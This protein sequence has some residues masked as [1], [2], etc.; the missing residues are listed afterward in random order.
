METT[1]YSPVFL[2]KRKFLIVAP[3]LM[4]PFITLFF[5][6][7]G[8]GKAAAADTTKKTEPDG[9]NL[10]LPE[11]KTKDEK[12]YNKLSFYE[13]ASKDS[14]KFQEELRNDPYSK[15]SP[16]L[17]TG[18]DTSASELEQVAEQSATRYGQNI[19][20]G[21]KSLNNTQSNPHNYT[22][23][24]EEKVMRKLEQLQNEINAKPVEVTAKTVGYDGPTGSKQM[25]PANP[26]VEKL[27]KMMS[28][29]KK[30]NE[31]DTEMNNINAMLD[32]IMSIQHPERIED[33]LR[34]NSKA[35]RGQVFMVSPGK[36]DQNLDNENANGTSADSRFNNMEDVL[37]ADDQSQH[38]I[39][40][41]IQETR[42]LVSGATVKLRLLNNIYINGVL[43]PRNNFV[44]G[45]VSLKGE[46]LTIGINNINYQNSLFPVS[47][48][49]YD[50]DG[51]EG[52]NI[53]GAITRD[54]AKQSA[55]RAIQG[56]GLT[57]L[58]PSFSAQAAG[59]GIEAAKSLLS[60]K[61]RLV[62]VTVKSGYRVLLKDNNTK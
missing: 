29:I 35:H 60:R 33:T 15:W 53:P 38:S 62:K 56:F 59:A 32:K 2:R 31:P 51:M 43:I 13:Q 7:L 61:V 30:G 47:L 10:H 6:A 27:E 16:K 37:Q 11:A 48:S 57:S 44:F 25:A 4:L 52:I 45:T 49:V 22:D 17:A 18:K 42:E 8:G 40:A 39:S 1:T 14:A 3:L 50:L 58:D 9:L 28:L 26:D 46:R 34:E 19:S 21:S 5:W 20:S 23:H 55:D 36:D 12:G 24:N 41:V 54:V